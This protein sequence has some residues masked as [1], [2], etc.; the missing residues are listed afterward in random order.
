MPDYPP[1]RDVPGAVDR[2]QAREVPNPLQW[3]EREHSDEVGQWLAQQHQLTREF[4]GRG[5]PGWCRN[6]R[7]V[8]VR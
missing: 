3:L 1:T 2:V 6:V 5:D 8:F 4:V 7:H